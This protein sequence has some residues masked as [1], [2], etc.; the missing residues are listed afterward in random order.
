MSLYGKQKK[1]TQQTLK[2]DFTKYIFLPSSKLRHIPKTNKRTK[3]NRI[4]YFELKRLPNF[5]E[6]YFRTCG[7]SH[8]KSILQL[9]GDKS[10]KK[11]LVIRVK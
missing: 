8:R 4:Y 7:S 5:V 3:N 6:N 11:T 1:H 2:T 9:S 10:Q